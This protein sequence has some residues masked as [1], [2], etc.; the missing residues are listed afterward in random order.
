MD[1][2]NKRVNGDVS[3]SKKSIV[4]SRY[5][6]YMTSEDEA[7]SSSA[8]SSEE[9]EEEEEETALKSVTS[10]Q[11]VTSAQSISPV[12][13]PVKSEALVN[14]SPAKETTQ[15]HV[16]KL[17]AVDKTDQFFLLAVERFEN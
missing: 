2:S 9:E 17:P 12:P 15:V 11:S 5:H 10:T 8:H 13:P 16:L 3:V 14:S 1:D 6:Q 4:P 7:Q